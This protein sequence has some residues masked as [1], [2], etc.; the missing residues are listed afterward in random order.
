MNLAKQQDTKWTHRNQWH[1]YMEKQ[2]TI[3]KENHKG[4]P[5]KIESKRI[6]YLGINQEGESCKIKATKFCWKKLKKT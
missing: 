3:W 2:E 5:L 6:K 4:V 1:F